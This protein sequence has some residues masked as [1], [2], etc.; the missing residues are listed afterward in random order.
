MVPKAPRERHAQP[1][2]TPSDVK[3]CVD[4]Q[5]RQ[6]SNPKSINHR[7]CICTPKFI[8][9]ISDV[10]LRMTR[11]AMTTTTMVNGDKDGDDDDDE[12]AQNEKGEAAGV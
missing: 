9:A 2:G 12:D 1:Q 8:V 7:C 11:I 3:L 5:F 4:P 10:V 6:F